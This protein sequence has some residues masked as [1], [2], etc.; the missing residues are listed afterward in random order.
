MHFDQRR[1]DG[2]ASLMG[3]NWNMWHNRAKW[4]SKSHW[5]SCLPKISFI[6]EQSKKKRKD[7][8]LWFQYFIYLFFLLK[9]MVLKS[10]ENQISIMLWHGHINIVIISYEIQMW[11][12]NSFDPNIRGCSSSP[13]LAKIC[14]ANSSSCLEPLSLY[15]YLFPRRCLKKPWL[16]PNFDLRP[17]K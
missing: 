3:L 2:M 17:L 13:C 1:G 7:G 5:N 8:L 4:I 6:R 15:P 16:P 11:N 10:W 14:D 12:Q 9:L